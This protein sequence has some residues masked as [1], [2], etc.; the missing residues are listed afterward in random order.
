[1]A[2]AVRSPVHRTA[3]AVRP[4]LGLLPLRN[5][6]CTCQSRDQQPSQL[7]TPSSNL[8]PS[9][10]F[11]SCTTSRKTRNSDSWFSN[12]SMHHTMA[13]GDGVAS[14]NG[15]GEGSRRSLFF[16]RRAVMYVPACDERKVL[17]TTTISVDSI[18]F[19]IEDGVAAN[20]KDVARKSIGAAIAT[21]R[22][23]DSQSSLSEH[24]VRV[25]GVGSGLMNLDLRE[26]F[27]SCDSHGVS[28]DAIMLP[29]VESVE[30]VA[31]LDLCLSFHR[32]SLPPLPLFIMAES[33]LGL[34]HLH[35]ICHFATHGTRHLRLAA[36]VFG[37]DDYLASIGGVRTDSGAELAAVRQA[38]VGVASAN[39]VAAIDMVST[40][41]SDLTALREQADEGAR[42][43]FNGK[44]VIHPAQVPVVQEAFSP[45]EERVEWASRL[46]S[47]FNHHQHSGQP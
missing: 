30:H 44:Q 39:G 22:R 37:S 16:P 18:I 8:A 10:N 11:T 15:G 19:D 24:V 35:H 33:P 3:I 41:F 32:L 5:A 31:E 17:K 34:L 36:V 25:N 6:A 2:G 42:M 47:A 40:N 20:K 45:S 21:S 7:S 9:R 13:T 29:K 23:D 14:S 4:V 27:R 38:V 28:P 1:M 12:H 43:G 46:I 26:V